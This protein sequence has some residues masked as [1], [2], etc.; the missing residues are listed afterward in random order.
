M[1]FEQKM[2]KFLFVIWIFALLGCTEQIDTSA[3]YVFKYNTAITYM[4]K[5]PESYGTYLDLLYKVPVSD[6]SKTT[7]G[8]LLNARGRYTV[9]APT[10]EAIQH[11]LDTLAATENFITSASWDAFTDS[12]KLD[13]IRRVI[14]FNSIIDSGDNNEVYETNDFPVTDGD[15]FP[16]AN[17]N[18]RKL[19][20][21][22]ANNDPDSIYINH[23]CPVNSRNRNIYVL[24]GIIHQVEKVIAPNELTAADYLS[25]IID[26]QEETYLVM[27]RAIQACGLMDTLRAT[28]DEEYEKKYRQGKVEDYVNKINGIIH[29]APE[30]RKYGFTIFAETDDFWRSEGIDPTAPNLMEQLQQWVYDHHQYADDDKFETDNNYKSGNNLL[31]Q[32]VTYHITPY[33]LPISKLVLHLNEYG[34]YITNPRSL[35]IPVYELY[36]SLGERRLIKTYESKASKGVFLNRFPTLDDRPNGTGQEVSCDPNNIGCMIGTKDERAVLNEMVNCIIYPIDA[37]MA[38]TDE[39]RD[40]FQKQRLRF[41]IMSLFP[42]AR[43]NDIRA[44]PS[45]EERDR[46]A[47]IPNPSVY[48]YCDNLWMNEA[49]CFMYATYYGYGLGNLQEDQVGIQ[50]IYDVT[51]TLPPVARTGTYELRYG[52]CS[53][54]IWSVV[55]FYLGNDL[56]R[57]TVTGIPIDMTIPMTSVEFGYEADTDDWEFNAEVDKHLRNNGYMKGCKSVCSQGTPGGSNRVHSNYF[58][59]IIA[60]RTL[61][62]GKT[63]YLRM[64]SVIDSPTRCLHLDYFEI[65]P[66]EIYDNPKKTEDIW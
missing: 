48:K 20:V 53:A 1:F 11:Y 34:Y 35:G 39:V 49:S 27:A 32:W 8:Q 19:I 43:N 56:D 57:L 2:K 22:Y 26:R 17:M 37:P 66:K 31:Y 33:R 51:I 25:R 38:Y 21:N 65:C 61:E 42:E 62:A 50:G 13:S 63:Y 47:L 40:N 60:R 46:M 55:Q 3:R 45:M 64:K 30:H 5:F 6:V 28:R 23:D 36:P 24:N 41:D 58:R 54:D 10:N 16:L 9:L 29:Y 18:D 15:E 44:K 14:V 4:Q 59:R 12:T 52:L 7:V